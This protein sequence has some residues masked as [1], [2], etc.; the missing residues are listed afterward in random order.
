MLFGWFWWFFDALWLVLVAFDALWL[1]LVVF[2]AS[3]I[4][5]GGF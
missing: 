3:L 4:G 1:V 2:D 5:A